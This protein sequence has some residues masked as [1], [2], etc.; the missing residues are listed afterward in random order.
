VE[1]GC[2]LAE[3]STQGYGSKRAVLPMMMMMMPMMIKSKYTPIIERKLGG[4]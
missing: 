4:S 2:I 1:T 3:N